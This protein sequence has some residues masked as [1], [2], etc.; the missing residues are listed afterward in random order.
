MEM[1]KETSGNQKERTG[2]E[3]VALRAMEFG[4]G[5]EN[6]FWFRDD[7]HNPYPISTLGMSTIRRAHMWAFAVTAEEAKLP[8]SRG[9][10]VK[11]HNSRIYDG[12]VN[13]TD[14]AIVQER[15]KQFHPYIGKQIQNF[16]ALYEE[17]MEE[18][19]QLTLPNVKIDL[20][21]LSYGELSQHVAKCARI[22]LRCW[23]LHFEGMYVANGIYLGGEQFAK[24]HGLEE[25]DFTS[26]LTGFETMRL[27][28]DR[29]QYQLCKSAFARD[30]VRTLL[31]SE[32][33]IENVITKLQQT[34]EG[35]L[36][37]KELYE[38]LDD[39]GHRLSA[40]IL[41]VNFPTWYEN[42]APIVENIRTLL[43]KVRR[44][45]NFEVD[46]QQT[47]QTR[48]EA[49]ER[50]TQMLSAEDRVVFE[51]KLP[52]WQ[53]A[54]QYNEDHW[55]YLE[56]VNFSG[57]R[58]AAIEA[59]KR[60]SELGV[61]DGKED[62]FRLTLEEILEAL[63]SCEENLEA[64]VHAYSHLLKP[65]TAYRKEEA[66]KA[67]LEKGNAFM[68]TIPDRVDDP[69]AIKIYGLTSFVLDKA[70]KEVA[71]ETLEVGPTINGFPGAPGVV[72]G[73]A[74]VALHHDELP[75]LKSG[76]ILVCRFTSP[77]WTPLF[78]KIKG[79][80][81]DS[82]GMLTHAAITAREYGI[83]AVVGTWVATESI[84]DGDII[85]IDGDEGVVQIISR[86]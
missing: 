76:D 11:T 55:F 73:P 3:P 65:L 37:W 80:V 81:T 32:E 13:I 2:E 77:A 50:F 40:A 83:P 60:L 59:G 15:A 25:K 31:E 42:P 38:Y 19:K 24:E 27:A 67:G 46:F 5:D 12:F 28:T 45:W 71:G 44:G 4:F 41:D 1:E 33:P 22:N 14:P 79:V 47:I 58:Y 29:G 17:I 75:K 10:V 63:E 68:G 74:R 34:T 20:R 70:R 23:Y 7:L 54:Y 52:L 72:E 48:K 62:I 56:Q 53:K 9:A 6:L 66:R 85:R 21:P 43:P 26:L 35:Q 82:G 49:V 18:G 39:F 57:L 36:W 86:A 78:P 61:I 69:L 30:E 51:Q 84:K 64:A 8:P 16:D